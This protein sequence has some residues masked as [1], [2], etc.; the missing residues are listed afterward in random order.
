MPRESFSL[1]SSP[2]C[3]SLK[4]ALGSF[5]AT[6]GSTT[7]QAKLKVDRIKKKLTQQN[8]NTKS[9]D[10]NLYLICGPPQITCKDARYSKN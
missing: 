8:G 6:L 9:L 3:Q 5:T 10:P 7:G 2:A 1:K 4:S